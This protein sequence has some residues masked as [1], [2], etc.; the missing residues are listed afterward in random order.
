MIRFFLAV[1]AMFFVPFLIYAAFVFVRRRGNL[2]GNLLEDAPVNWLAVAG[3]IL[4][5]GTFASLVSMEIIEYEQGSQAPSLR[6]GQV[7]P[8]RGP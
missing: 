2:E 5:V 7:K 1:I 3:T 8:G 6:E 4:A